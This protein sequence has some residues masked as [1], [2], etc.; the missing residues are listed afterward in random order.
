MSFSLWLKSL[1][2]KSLY[3]IDILWWVCVCVCV[4][5]YVWIAIWFVSDSVSTIFFMIRSH[6]F[7]HWSRIYPPPLHFHRFCAFLRLYFCV[8]ITMSVL[9]TFSKQL[10]VYITARESPSVTQR[11]CMCFSVRE[12][13]IEK[14]LYVFNCA[15]VIV[16]ICSSETHIR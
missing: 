1:I 14:S 6:L 4:H 5:V 12:N 13:E 9:F 2:E 15:Y 16:F 10:Y 11:K 7:E 8:H 3:D